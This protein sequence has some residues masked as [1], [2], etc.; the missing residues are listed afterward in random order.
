MCNLR[1]SHEYDYHSMLLRL[2][3]LNRLTNVI[4]PIHLCVA[5]L[6]GLHQQFPRQLREYT[7][8]CGDHQLRLHEVDPDELPTTYHLNNNEHLVAPWQMQCA[9]LSV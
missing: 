6:P 4:I 7:S 2:A 5:K 9:L 3:L 8:P 1:K